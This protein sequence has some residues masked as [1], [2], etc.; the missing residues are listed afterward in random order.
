MKL[1]IRIARIS[2]TATILNAAVLLLL[3]VVSARAQI[4]DTGPAGLARQMPNIYGPYLANISRVR[5][6]QKRGKL[7]PPVYPGSK[8]PT[9][10]PPSQPTGHPP[11]QSGPIFP[12]SDDTT[13]QSQQPPFVPEQLAQ[14]LGKTPQ[15]KQYIEGV[16]TKCLTFYTDTARQKAVPLNDVALALNYYLSTNYFVYSN[17]QGP[18][19]DQMSATRDMIRANM[20]QDDAFRK[21]SDRQKQ[22]TYETLIVLAGFVDLGYGTAKQRGDANAAAQF[23]EM[24]KYNLETMLGAPIAK[25]HYTTDGL[26][27]N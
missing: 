7:N 11:G 13:F 8:P 12:V 10:Q 20:A 5:V 14:K 17:G 4:F 16:F 2:R 24:A 26:S 18:T 1:C 27:V 15:E 3:P 25:I 19:K 23:R 9:K 22:E 6:L 21:M